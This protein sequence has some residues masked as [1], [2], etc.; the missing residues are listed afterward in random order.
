MLILPKASLPRPFAREVFAEACTSGS[1][2]NQ[3]NIKGSSDL[4][5]VEFPNTIHKKFQELPRYHLISRQREKQVSSTVGYDL[6]HDH[7]YA[8]RRFAQA[9]DNLDQL[10]AIFESGN[11]DEFI[12][13]VE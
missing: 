8:E 5:R 3:A 6:M 9:H 12:K 4:L 2:G 11:L 13:V 7:P 10:I 1:E